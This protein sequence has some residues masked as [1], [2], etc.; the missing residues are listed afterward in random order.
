MSWIPENNSTMLETVSFLWQNI[1]FSPQ[2]WERGNCGSLHCKCKCLVWKRWK[3]ITM[4]F[5]KTQTAVK[6]QN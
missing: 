2:S 6:E 5:A 3:K 4:L 1:I